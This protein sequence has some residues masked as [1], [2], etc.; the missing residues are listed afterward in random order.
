MQKPR[1]MDVLEQVIDDEGAFKRILHDDT[2]GKDGLGAAWLAK[3]SGY[4]PLSIYPALDEAKPNG[5]SW[6]HMYAAMLGSRSIATKVVSW[7]TARCLPHTVPQCMGDVLDAAFQAEG[8]S[9]ESRAIELAAARDRQITSDEMGE[10]EAAWAREDDKREQKRSQFRAM[11]KSG[12]R[13]ETISR[14]AVQG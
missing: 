14:K 9:L 5:M 4:R 8:A 7:L 13:L 12:G 2:L 10:I 1:A 6:R 3:A 11:A